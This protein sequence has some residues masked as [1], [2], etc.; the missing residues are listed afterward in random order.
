[1]Q[2][3]SQMASWIKTDIDAPLEKLRAHVSQD[4]HEIFITIAEYDSSYVSYLRKNPLDDEAPSFLTMHQYGPWN[5]THA[6][7]MKKL[8]PILLALTLYAEAEVQKTEASLS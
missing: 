4:R 8:G 3:G 1:M 6:G 7:H 5:T 2:E